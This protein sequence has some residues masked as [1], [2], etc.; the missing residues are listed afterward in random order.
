MKQPQLS[1]TARKPPALHDG[2]GVSKTM[3][4]EISMQAHYNSVVITKP[5]RVCMQAIR[6]M[7]PSSMPCQAGTLRGMN[8]QNLFHMQNRL[9]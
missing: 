7:L 2:M 4:G 5:A 1:L 6:V 9:Q 8:K 3:T